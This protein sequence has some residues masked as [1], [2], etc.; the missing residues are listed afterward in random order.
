MATSILDLAAPTRSRLRKVS[1]EI[2]RRYITRAPEFSGALPVYLL[3]FPGSGK[4]LTIS[5]IQAVQAA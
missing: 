1:A 4:S 3:P 5:R 2:G